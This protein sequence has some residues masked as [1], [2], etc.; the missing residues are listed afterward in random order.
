MTEGDEE[1]MGQS[2][3]EDTHAI[4]GFDMNAATN[5]NLLSLDEGLKIVNTIDS[6][7]QRGAILRTCMNHCG[8]L[9]QQLCS[10]FKVLKVII[11]FEFFDFVNASHQ[12]RIMGNEWLLHCVVGGIVSYAGVQVCNGCVRGCYQR[13]QVKEDVAMENDKAALPLPM[14]ISPQNH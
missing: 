12:I 4:S 8:G 11:L 2:E 9:C 3:E 1:W 7:K 5:S 10:K 14:I 13:C 6:R